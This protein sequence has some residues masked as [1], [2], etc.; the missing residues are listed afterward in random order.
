M[1]AKWCKVK[2]AQSCL[3]PC[4]GL[5]SRPEYWSG[6]PFPSPGDLPNPGNEPRS[7]A[8]QADSLPAGALEKPK[9]T[10]VGSLS[11]LQRIFLTQETRVSCITSG[12]F[13][14]WATREAITSI[15]WCNH[16]YNDLSEFLSCFFFFFQTNDIHSST[17]QRTFLKLN[18]LELNWTIKYKSNSSHQSWSSSIIIS[19]M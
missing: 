10:R 18:I 17:C 6:Q 16:L 9:N 12:F 2:V 8:L 15:K 14:S 5:F 3:T 11:F 7:P 1:K 13:T 4:H 19:P